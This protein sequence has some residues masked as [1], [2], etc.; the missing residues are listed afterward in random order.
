MQ[1][2]KS[3]VGSLF[4]LVLLALLPVSLTI[5][6]KAQE[7][8]RNGFVEQIDSRQVPEYFYIWMTPENLLNIANKSTPNKAWPGFYKLNQEGQ[9]FL[10]NWPSFKNSRRGGIYAWTNPSAMMSWPGE[11]Y[12]EVLVRFKI[13]NLNLSAVKVSNYTRAA[14]THPDIERQ[15]GDVNNIDLAYH[16]TRGIK[17]WILLNPDMI[18]EVTA[19]PEVLRE[20][21]EKTMRKL[22][23]SSY[24]FSGDEVHATDFREPFEDRT[25]RLNSPGERNHAYFRLERFLKHGRNIVPDRFLSKKLGRTQTE[26]MREVRKFRTAE[27]QIYV[28]EVIQEQPINL[29]MYDVRTHASNLGETVAVKLAVEYYANDI[30]NTLHETLSDFLNLASKLNELIWNAKLF[31]QSI[32]DQIDPDLIDKLHQGELSVVKFL[33]IVSTKMNDRDFFSTL[34]SLSPE[35]ES[36]LSKTDSKLTHK[37]FNA[38]CVDVL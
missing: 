33:R 35:I 30:D 31:S 3:Q 34:Q 19:D 17:E 9:V 2:V 23:D 4:H 15:L 22:R 12:G 26:L 29:K 20:E 11:Y 18:T 7:N 13:D 38:I 1:S 27:Q 28:K 36:V 8:P 24:K 16:E 32:Y 25:N 37:N 14:D 5:V 6:S 10:K 21:I